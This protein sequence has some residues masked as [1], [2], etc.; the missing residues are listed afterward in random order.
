M[1]NEQDDF[2]MTPNTMHESRGRQ[3]SDRERT[4]PKS[5]IQSPM[6]LSKSNDNSGLL[7]AV[8]STDAKIR[9]FQNKQHEQ[10]IAATVFS[11]AVSAAL[12]REYLNSES[13]ICV[14]PNHISNFEAPNKK[15]QWL[16]LSEV[17]ME[18]GFTPVKAAE[19]LENVFSAFH[20]PNQVRLLFLVSSDAGKTGKTGDRVSVHIGLQ[21]KED[22][23]TDISEPN[24][25]SGF[26]KSNWPG[27]SLES[28]ED[29]NFD[30]AR[31]A[32]V[33]L[34]GVRI[35]TGIPSGRSKETVSATIDKLTGA[36]SG[37]SWRYLV[38]A[39]PISEHE[40]ED[41]IRICR[42]LAGRAES[43][44][45]FQLSESVSKTIGTNIT[46]S[47]GKSSS[48]SSREM[49]KAQKLALVATIGAGV[50]SVACPALLPAFL[51]VSTTSAMGT[52][53]T[54]KAGLTMLL[55]LIGGSILAGTSTETHGDTVSDTVSKSL[56]ESENFS[57]SQTIVNKH[58]EEAVKLIES[59]I[60]RFQL[61][62]GI[63]AWETGVYFV[64]E[65]ETT[66]EIGS[67]VLK[68]LI[69]GDNSHQEPIRI[70]NPRGCSQ[71][72][73]PLIAFR[74][75]GNPYVFPMNAG[76][77]I[78][79]PLGKRFE[80]L[81]TVVNTRELARLINFPLSNVPGVPVKRIAADT[82]FMSP[83]C[84]HVSTDCISIGNQIYRGSV[85][86]GCPYSIQTA[87]LAK[88]ALVCGINGSGKTN[89][90]LGILGDLLKKEIPFLVI[91]PAKQEYVDW[92]IKRNNLILGKYKGQKAKA[93][94]DPSWINVYIPG[95]DKWRG[96][97]LCKLT[98]N[99][100]DF[101]WLNS[102][103]EPKVL[104]HIDR[105]KTII[106]AALPMQESLPIL[107]EELIFAVYG[108]PFSAEKPGDKA[109]CWLP[110]DSRY[111]T[112]KFDECI[113]VPTFVQM[114]SQLTNLFE[115][116]T[117]AKD[118]QCNLQAALKTRIES[119]KRGWRKQLLNK[120]I[121][122]HSAEDWERLF[123]H[124]TVINLTSLTSD[125]DKAFFMAI[126]LMFIYEYRQEVAELP[127]AQEAKGHD[128]GLKH[129]LVVEEAHRVLGRSEG[130][131][132]A[133]A[134]APK[135]KVSEMF[136]NM[137]S[138]VRAYGQGILIADQI[139]SRLNE[140]A[141]KNTNLK[142]V[143]KLVSADDRKSMATA[144]N[145][146]DNQERVIGD[147]NV[148]EALVRGDMDKEAY[149]VKVNKN[150]PI[151]HKQSFM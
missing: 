29:V 99:P 144:L 62:E 47:K 111:R 28:V 2:I 22:F 5:S 92:A 135:Q 140:D 17:G 54:A 70:F 63:G 64:G 96:E 110:P 129:L 106:N 101:V 40:M 73:S 65:D 113:P 148:G 132:S 35:L 149:M 50:L 104:E 98:L 7:E 123:G 19:A 80:N 131:V 58:A 52:V 11:A 77:V 128:S 4:V 137:I 114:A 143:H 145:V 115:R 56:S 60:A 20:I 124:P 82:G 119:F 141:V 105:L 61:C 25:I 21:H 48:S 41:T 89:T 88:H 45:S 26:L 146:W 36:L 1:S 125:E 13:N 8:N 126:V 51:T 59:Q 42:E 139:P 27:V 32:N 150:G 31:K 138:E 121:P 69:S 16:K 136:S 91:E 95:R 67:N 71:E 87:L 94:A 24:F 102:T 103:E 117:Y 122:R 30:F 78:T 66:A 127:E 112:P 90:I 134:A 81:R 116:L 83:T 37:H 151:S 6:S 57:F 39:D 68:S 46:H 120:D 3:A 75:F 86:A 108:V 49:S 15:I 107:M 18:D 79:H 142:I 53:V 44:K 34:P 9:A 10:T 109:L 38:V 130:A 14:Q 12:R 133:F 100:F 76:E 85:L 33:C 118:V 84:S 55:S 43:M 74:H 23:Q 147:L 72:S 93:K 97:D